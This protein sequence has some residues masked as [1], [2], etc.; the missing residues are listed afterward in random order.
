[1][2]KGS[3]IAFKARFL[4]RELAYTYEVVEYLPHTRLVMQTS[5][6]PF[7]MKTTYSWT[8]TNDKQTRMTLRNTGEPSGFS[9]WFSPFISKLMRKANAKDL[10]KLK[11]ILE[12]HAGEARSY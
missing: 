1:L 2:D 10:E 8:A 3:R 5:E 12:K 6:G 11:M 7:P 9:K 4:G